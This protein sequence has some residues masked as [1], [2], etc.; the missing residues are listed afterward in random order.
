MTDRERLR[1]LA[2]HARDDD[3]DEAC[4]LRLSPAQLELALALDPST[5]LQL[6]E[7]AEA[8][9]SFE[10]A[11]QAICD[12][13]RALDAR[14]DAL[15]KSWEAHAFKLDGPRTGRRLELKTTAAIFYDC[16]DELRACVK[17]ER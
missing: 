14:L 9:T 11:L 10:L 5:V 6:V 16:A 1:R 12:E 8:R 3:R 15:I 17:R 4:A 7:E 2:L 13:V